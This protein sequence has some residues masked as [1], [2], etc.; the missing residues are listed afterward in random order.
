L[1]DKPSY[2][3]RALSEGGPAE[4]ADDIGTDQT[5]IRYGGGQ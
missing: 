2:V 3:V 1:M 4:S 5:M